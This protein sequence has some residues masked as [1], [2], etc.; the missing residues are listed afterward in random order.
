M[1]I[2]TATKMTAEE[3]FEWA[4]RPEFADKRLELDNGEVVEM[5]SPGE[6]HALVCWLVIKVLT[7]YVVRR[8]R[9]HIL[10]N[11]CGLVVRR[12]PDTVR[13]P[14][15]MLSLDD[16]SLD[17]ASPGHSTR[18]PTLVVEVYSPSDKPAQYGRRV[19]QYHERGVPLVWVVYPEERSVAVC[20]PNEF[21][22]TL[23]ETDELT[24]NGVL[25][26]FA[27]KVRDLFT[28]PGAPPP[29]S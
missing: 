27:C 23:D 10:T 7:E 8:G 13:G 14:D 11:D 1:A 19:E 5:P 6:A 9:G 21:P 16:L 26:D 24:G 28:S 12:N 18:V 25:P 3:F 22:K 17:D 20:H 29:S 4:N 2:T 15:V